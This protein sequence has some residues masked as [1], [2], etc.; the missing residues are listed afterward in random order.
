MSC[1]YR[2]VKQIPRKERSHTESN[3]TSLR[4]W[5]VLGG[6]QKKCPLE[7]IIFIQALEVRAK[8]MVQAFKN[9]SIEEGILFCVLSRQSFTPYLV[10]ILLKSYLYLCPR[11]ESRGSTNIHI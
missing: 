9:V 8:E 2:Y 6:N 5:S 4:K 1:K 7:N 3:K 10:H 11:S